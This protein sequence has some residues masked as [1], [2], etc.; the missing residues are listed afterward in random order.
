MR[1]K[2]A[3]IGGGIVGLSIAYNLVKK[4]ERDVVI[5]DRKHIGYGSSTRS[6]AQFR[7]HFWADENA[8]FAIESRKIL[9]KAGGQLNFNPL[10]ESNG[11]LWLLYD[12]EIL[13]A[14]HRRNMRWS[15]L[16]VAGRLLSPEDVRVIHP[17]INTQGMTGAFYGPQNG[18]LHHDF[19]MF[20]YRNAIL[21]EGGKVL[22]YLEAKKLLMNGNR[23]RA[24][25]TSSEPIEANKVVVAAGVWSNEILQTVGLQLPI[26]PERKEVCVTEPMKPFIKTFVINTKL[27]SFLIAQT[28]RGEGIGSLDHPPVKGTLQ[29]G[30][31]IEFLREFSRAAIATIP[32]LRKA[33]M[34]RVWSG[35]YEVTPDH[36]HILGRNPEWPESLYV[37]AGF[38]GHGLMMAPLVGKVMAELL[39]EEKVHPLMKPYSPTRFEEGKEIR[40]TLVIG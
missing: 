11:Y 39:L 8:L 18:R 13:E 10:V 20:G 7:T 6:V 9:L 22:E 2:V 16:G 31:T 34:L 1:T 15:E 32:A 27:K 23:I 3:I 30:N 5:I 36:S 4:G 38:S 12:D 21:K 24:I 33:R 40:E 37:A 29:P 14:Y 35:F 26:T 25:E 28:L 19:L 17:Y